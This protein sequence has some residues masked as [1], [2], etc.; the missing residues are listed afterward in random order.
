MCIAKKW[1]NKITLKPHHPHRPTVA[2]MSVSLALSQ[3]ETYAARPWIWGQC[4]CVM[5]PF[6]PHRLLNTNTYSIY[7][8]DYQSNSVKDYL[9]PA[10]RTIQSMTR[11]PWEPW[12]WHALT[13]HVHG[14]LKYWQLGQLWLDLAWH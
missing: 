3:T 10:N 13:G 6:T 7:T 11:G 14:K 8:L 2:L 4:S 5:C 1:Q 9:L 12:T